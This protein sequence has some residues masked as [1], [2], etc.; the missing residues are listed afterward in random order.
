[1]TSN[2]SPKPEYQPIVHHG[3][4]TFAIVKGPMNGDNRHETVFFRL[5]DTR[6]SISSLFTEV[7]GFV[8]DAVQAGEVATEKKEELIRKSRIAISSWFSKR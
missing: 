2:P 3:R 4:G 7:D 1:M 6:T 5:L 8:E